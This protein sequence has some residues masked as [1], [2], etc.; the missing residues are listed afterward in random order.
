MR[1][2]AGWLILG[3]F[4]SA[5]TYGEPA[6]QQV[7]LFGTDFLRECEFVA[8]DHTSLLMV[9][10]QSNGTLSVVGKPTGYL[11]TK[12]SYK[13]FRL[14]LDWR[15][16]GKAGNSGVLLHIASGPLDRNLWPRCLQVQLKHNQAGDLLPMAGASFK[17]PLSVAPAGSPAQFTHLAADSE[18]AVGEWNHCDIVCKEGE[19]EVSINGVRQSRV[20][21]CDP[22]EGH[23]GLQLEGAP[24]EIRLAQIE[25]L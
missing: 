17:E 25:E 2:P 11:Q 18:R 24:Y 3:S 10:T 5:V 19:V 16:T 23:V 1:F 4:A 14:V 13:N 22:A 7:D 8:P 9:C 20:T 21:G 6:R 12:R 15:W